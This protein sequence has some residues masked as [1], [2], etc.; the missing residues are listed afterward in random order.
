MNFGTYR[1]RV[2]PIR[3]SDEFSTIHDL[4]RREKLSRVLS[5][6]ESSIENAETDADIY[7]ATEEARQKVLQI[8]KGAGTHDG[9]RARG[10][11]DN[12][13]ED[14]YEWWEKH[15]DSI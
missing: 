5:T 11:V 6:A 8:F 4:D 3:D 12:L 13:T 14:A 2:A 1:A 7:M 10:L 15:K 9:F